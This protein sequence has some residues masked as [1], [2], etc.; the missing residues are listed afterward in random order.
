MQGGRYRS[1]RVAT[2]LDW[3][4]SRGFAGVGQTSWGP[5]GFVLLDSEWRSLELLAELRT[6]FRA[7]A[8]LRF[9]LSRGRNRGAEVS[10]ASGS[11]QTAAAIASGA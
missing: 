11:P 10:L 8:G 3:L 5:T 1:P 6:R 2:V 4:A 7:E 9:A